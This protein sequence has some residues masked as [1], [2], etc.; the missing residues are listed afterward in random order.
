MKSASATADANISSQGRN[1]LVSCSVISSIS[2][3]NTLDPTA[4]EV[5]QTRDFCGGVLPPVA[6]EM[7]EPKMNSTP[8][9]KDDKLVS[10]SQIE[11]KIIIHFA[12]NKGT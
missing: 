8:T 1:R 11:R 6:G 9:K 2:P 4:S 12:K 7:E 10:R 3:G 5:E